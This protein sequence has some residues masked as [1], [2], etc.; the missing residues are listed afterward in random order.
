[1]TDPAL[2][3]WQRIGLGSYRGRYLWMTFS[4][5][6]ALVFIALEAQNA[7]RNSA[8]ETTRQ[9][10]QHASVIGHLTDA[11]QLLHEL[12]G[13]LLAF[14]L[15]PHGSGSREKVIEVTR[16]MQ[17]KFAALGAIPYIDVADYKGTVALLAT[18]GAKLESW[19]GKLITLRL[20]PA[21]WVPASQ[22]MRERMV[23]QAKIVSGALQDIDLLLQESPGNDSL[24]L[25]A[26]QLQTQ[27][28]HVLGEMR[29]MVANRFGTFSVDT[30]AGI[31]TR[32]HNLGIYLQRFQQD[33]GDFTLR[34]VEQD[35]AFV[36]ESLSTLHEAVSSWV[37]GYQQLTLL[38]SQDGWRQD[39][40]MLD[41]H[42][43]PLIERMSQS[44]NASRLHLQS[45][46]QGQLLKLLGQA[47]SL[48]S[49]IGWLTA[50]LIGLFG[51]G[52]LAYQ[53]WLLHPIEHISEQLQR[54]GR[55]ELGITTRLPPVRE[56]RKLVQSFSEMHE[57]V[58]ARERRLDYMAYHD[59]LTGLP[60]RV[61]FHER[62]ND[63]LQ[64][65]LPRGH[66]VGVLFMDLDRFK[67]IND[68]HGHLIGD[69]LLIEVARR[70]R[71]AFRSE[72]LVARLSGDEFAVLLQR[73]GQTEEIP[74]L[75]KK[76]IDVVAQ[77]YEID[78]ISFRTSASVGMSIAPLHGNTAASL[79]QQADTAMYHAKA[80]GRAMF[81]QFSSD[82]LERSAAQLELENDLHK[83]FAEGQF[84]LFSQPILDC[85][86]LL[87]YAR[88][89]LIRWQ[90][91]TRGLMS[92]AEFLD[93]LEDLGLDRDLTDWILDLLE[94][95]RATTKMAYTINLSARQLSDATFL[96]H[97]QQRIRTGEIQADRLIIEITE[98][99]L[100][101][102][103]D[104]ITLQLADL[105][106]IG[107][108]IALD[109]FGTGQSSLSHLRAFPFDTVKIDR[110]FV[111]DILEDGQDATLIRAIIGLAHTLDMQVVAEGVETSAQHAFLKAE[112]CDLVQGYLLGQPAPM[113]PERQSNVVPLV[114]NSANNE[115]R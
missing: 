90:H 6:I 46:T 66:D 95:T 23:P 48:A 53:R 3:I 24:R 30:G 32:G 10:A 83:A 86:S 17:E 65:E 5:S 92:P 98:D 115:T 44:L 45:D 84:R 4:L 35:L 67:Q 62:L 36:V 29:L 82:M 43:I 73:F 85:N 97:L 114:A 106:A 27:W 39:L 59:P 50:I 63:A 41:Q 69:K 55:G 18:D 47:E 91:P 42:I 101:D 78:G 71:S 8:A 111:R 96:S 16:Q 89:C 14:T 94:S 105:Q 93:T 80:S 13:E 109:D 74:G 79:I 103:L 68:T 19:I 58:R 102:D 104:R 54:E 77:P 70:L 100:S 99:T 15:D 87:P 107:V 75:A 52:Y 88:E 81:A 76:A 12:R 72:D 40:V 38:I 11:D 1:M 9:T 28:L 60:N 37:S 22:T 51:L 113:L 112:G 49:G 56:T 7:V 21:Q 64:N 108:R 26:A 34:A 20:D 57:K 33:L 31:E 25:A 61:L 110:S 2:T